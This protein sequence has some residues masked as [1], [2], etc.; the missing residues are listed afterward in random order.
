MSKWSDRYSSVVKATR[1]GVVKKASEMKC[2]RC[3]KPAR[4]RHHDDYRK[5]LEVVYLC[6]D[7]H[8]IRHKELGWGISGRR[9]H[10]NFSRI[11]VGAYGL[12]EAKMGHISV[13][14]HNHSVKTGER[15]K[16]FQ[17][18]ANRAA[19]FRLPD[20]QPLGRPDGMKYRLGSERIA[21]GLCWYCEAPLA[22][23]RCCIECSV[24]Q[25]ERARL[26]TGSTRHN[27]CQ[28]RRLELQHQEAA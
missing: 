26:R 28:S 22:T 27:N 9:K 21:A 16:C 11:P 2:E 5:P 14:V 7:C 23:K 19:V 17:F 20:N 12:I 4:Q 10:Y 6:Y 1:N 8:K 18:D 3:G 13:S 25:R 24:A 15:F